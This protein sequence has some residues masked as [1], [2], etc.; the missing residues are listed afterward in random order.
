MFPNKILA[1]TFRIIVIQVLILKIVETFR[2]SF[3]QSSLGKES[4]F[5]VLLPRLDLEV[6]GLVLEAK[7]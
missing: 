7:K 4:L 2:D 3:D 6:R 1:F 5:A